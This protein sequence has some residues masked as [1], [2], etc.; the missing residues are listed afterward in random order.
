[1]RSVLCDDKTFARLIGDGDLYDYELGERYVVTPAASFDH[2][3]TQAALLIALA[4]HFVKVS[5]PTNL[6]LLGEQG[7]RWYVVPD[8]V[9]APDDTEG[10]PALLRALIAVEIRSADEDTNA[11]LAGYR[12]VMARTGLELG[13][14]WYV[15]GGEVT[16]HPAAAD[17]PGATA[18]PDAL[19]AVRAALS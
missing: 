13:E 9:V 10:G 12:A 15:D 2:G 3:T 11:K 6:G 5:G 18:W 1:M 14:V 8:A 7:R 16:V 17:Q 19:D 4:R